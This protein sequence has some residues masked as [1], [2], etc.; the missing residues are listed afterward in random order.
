MKYRLQK[1]LTGVLVLVAI[2]AFCAYVMPV[3]ESY[4]QTFG[5]Q[6]YKDAQASNG[7]LAFVMLFPALIGLC[8]IADSIFGPLPVEGDAARGDDDKD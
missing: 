1:A 6:A 5:E 3:D 8:L 2:V 4:R 7:I